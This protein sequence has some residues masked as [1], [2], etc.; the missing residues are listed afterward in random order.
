MEAAI[1]QAKLQISTVLK[2]IKPTFEELTTA[3]SQVEAILNS[4]P[5]TPLTSDPNDFSVFRLFP[6]W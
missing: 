4:R 5:L 1:K 6:H 3:I 2:N